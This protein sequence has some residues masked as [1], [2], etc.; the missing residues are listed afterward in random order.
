MHVAYNADNVLVVSRAPNCFGEQNT[1][2]EVSQKNE[3]IIVNTT[4]Q[5]NH[6]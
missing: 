2:T 1:P 6:L 3:T 5:H 4:Q